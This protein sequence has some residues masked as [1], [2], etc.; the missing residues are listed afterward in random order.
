M[1]SVPGTVATSRSANVA[2][3]KARASETTNTAKPAGAAP[4]ARIAISS[5]LACSRDRPAITPSSATNGT[6]LCSAA[7][8]CSV[9]IHSA[10][11]PPK[12]SLSSITET[13]SIT[14]T[15]TSNVTS[16]P[17]SMRDAA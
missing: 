17:A 4:Q 16:M 11:T 3:S 6:K 9:A 7:G 10:V 15:S 13:I 1:R 14:D 5:W 12:R 8:S 2:K